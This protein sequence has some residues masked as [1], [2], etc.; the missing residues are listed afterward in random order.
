MDIIC[1]DNGRTICYSQGMYKGSSVGYPFG[2]WEQHTLGVLE[3][4]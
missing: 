4:I 1:I 2:T 3:G